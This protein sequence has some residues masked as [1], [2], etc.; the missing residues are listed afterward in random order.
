MVQSIDGAQVRIRQLD[1]DIQSVSD[2]GPIEITR[3]LGGDLGAG[4][5]ELVNRSPAFGSLT[6][7][8]GGA[9]EDRFSGTLQIRSGDRVGIELGE[10]PDL[11]SYLMMARDYDID[12]INQANPEY[13]AE[14]D[15]EIATVY[16][17]DYALTRLSFINVFRSF[18]DRPVAG[19]SDA[20][21]NTLLREELPRQDQIT[22]GI[23]LR[24]DAFDS[25]TDFVA[26]GQSMLRCIQQLADSVGAVV[27]TDVTSEINLPVARLNFRDP[28]AVG[29]SPTL[30]A[31]DIE[32]GG[33]SAT[34]DSMQNRIRVEG[35]QRTLV[36][37]EQPTVDSYETVDNSTRKVAIA[38]SP[39]N[40]VPSVQIATNRV[41]DGGALRAR[42]QKT[43]GSGGALD[44]A[45]PTKDLEQASLTPDFLS[46]SDFTRFRFQG[47]SPVP[48]DI[49]LIVDTT[50]G[51]Q[52]VG[53]DADGNLA[54][55]VEY[56]QPIVA[57]A[58]A[59]QSQKRF[60]R[61]D[62][63]VSAGDVD[64]AAA[65][66]DR[67]RIEL[68]GSRRPTEELQ[69]EAISDAAHSLSVFDRP[70]IDVG[71]PSIQGEYIVTEVSESIEGIQRRATISAVSPNSIDIA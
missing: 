19:S 47:G 1:D 11:P 54:Y 20:I 55:R 9:F 22:E 33:Y 26:D 58:D 44:P 39:K 57:R 16:L 46:Q 43:D 45:D 40:T 8:A 3:R 37:D 51:N 50:G 14:T 4:S 67:G 30:G 48:E 63:R 28:D 49:A 71:P 68:Q 61:R 27:T 41:S 34:D 2:P 25:T 23:E 62:K 59:G 29:A 31:G 69:F 53:V 65:A 42:I 12:V 7:P 13:D 70:F 56:E 17:T 36:A 10:S 64:S 35:P 38:S 32:I 66:R 18:E 5:V 6:D 24:A 52:D 60:L 15:L 21:V